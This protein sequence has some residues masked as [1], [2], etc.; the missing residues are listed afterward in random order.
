[1]DYLRFNDLF[2]LRLTPLYPLR[3]HDDCNWAKLPVLPVFDPHGCL[4]KV[5]RVQTVY[6]GCIDTVRERR[7]RN[8]NRHLYFRASVLC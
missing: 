6:K 2:T 1:M 4:V 5:G 8:Y 7:W 3:R